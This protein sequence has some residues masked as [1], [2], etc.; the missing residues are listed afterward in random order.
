MKHPCDCS[1]DELVAAYLADLHHAQSIGSTVHLGYIPWDKK[2]GTGYLFCERH[3][4]YVPV[5]GVI[6]K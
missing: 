1:M 3:R 6:Y 4:V 5:E 2:K